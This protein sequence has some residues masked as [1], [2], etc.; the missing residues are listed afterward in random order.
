MPL[1][2]KN[3]YNQISSKVKIPPINK[4]LL[5]KLL[6]R[7]AAAAPALPV[8]TLS[9]DFGRSKIVFL[10]VEKSAS[11]VKLLKFQKASRAADPEKDPEVL[12]QTFD[13]GAYSTNKVRI[14]VKGQGVIVRFI[15]FPTMKEADLRSAITYEID[16]YIPFKSHEVIWDISILEE[17]VPLTAGGTGLSVLLAAV[18]RE[19]LYSLITTFQKAGLEIELIDVDAL[20]AVNAFEYF[21]PDRLTK[22][23]AFLDIGSEIST[24]SI[25]QN[26]KP[27]FIRDISFG[28]VDILKRMKRKLGL[29]EEQARTQIEVDQAPTPEAAAILKESLADLVS[30][31]KVSLNYYLDQVPSSEPVKNLFIGGG[32]GYHPIVIET[33]TADLGFPVET[34]DI[35]SKVQLAEGMDPQILKTNQG[36]LPVCLGLAVRES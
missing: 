29:T 11:G 18:K 3:I 34:L 10:E 35:L 28:G 9:C 36:L 23:A 5:S 31:L 6:K 30:D 16:Q 20:S 8:S 13:A 15:Q 2:I 21:H 4:E 17:N 19:D 24:L 1:Q 14:S 33:L 7:E 12:K 22:P 32:G 26:S 25:I 27:R